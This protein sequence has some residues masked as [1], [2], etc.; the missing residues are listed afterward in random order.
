MVEASRALG[1]SVVVPV[2][3]PSVTLSCTGTLLTPQKIYCFQSLCRG[4]AALAKA[5]RTTATILTVVAEAAMEAVVAVAVAELPFVFTGRRG[6]FG[7]NPREK[8]SGA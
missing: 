2:T 1:R 3:C 7:K 5:A 8:H 6:T 4:A